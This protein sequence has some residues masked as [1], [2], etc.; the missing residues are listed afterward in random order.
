MYRTLNFFIV[1]LY[2][3]ENS[4]HNTSFEFQTHQDLQSLLEVAEGLGCA[5]AVFRNYFWPW[6]LPDF[7]KLLTERPSR[8]TTGINHRYG[9]VMNGAGCLWCNEIGNY[10]KGGEKNINKR[11]CHSCCFAYCRWYISWFKSQN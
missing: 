9:N 4:L 5:E 11:F 8:T 7:E 2:R 1:V 3:L 10:R 6:N